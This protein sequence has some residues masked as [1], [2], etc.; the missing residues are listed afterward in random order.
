MS[1]QFN[2]FAF[3]CISL[4]LDGELLRKERTSSQT[5][6]LDWV[7]NAISFYGSTSASVNIDLPSGLQR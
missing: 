3:H 7:Y 1:T 6:R 5:V 2:H 4:G